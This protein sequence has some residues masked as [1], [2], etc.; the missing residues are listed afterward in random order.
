MSY[1]DGDFKFSQGWERH[2]KQCSGHRIEVEL[3]L[4]QRQTRRRMSKL[5]DFQIGKPSQTRR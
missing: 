1:V 5:E 2:F 3:L 4:F